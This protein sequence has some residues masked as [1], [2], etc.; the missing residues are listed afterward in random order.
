[1]NSAY[2]NQFLDSS[3]VVNLQ[4]TPGATGANNTALYLGKIYNLTSKSVGPHTLSLLGGATFLDGTTLK[5]FSGT[6]STMTISPFVATN[7]AILAS[8]GVV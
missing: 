7:V 2:L 3:G 8:A 5:T 1:M 6:G 4:L